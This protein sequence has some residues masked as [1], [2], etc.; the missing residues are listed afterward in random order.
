[1]SPKK[2]TSIFKLAL[3][4]FI[5]DNAI[6]AGAALAYYAIFAI[7]PLILLS[8][9]LSRIFF[10]TNLAKAELSDFLSQFFG[11]AGSK[12]IEIILANETTPKGNITAIVL[13]IIIL[14]FG[15]MG[16][17]Y[18]IRKI[19]DRMWNVKPD[20]HSNKI[21]SFLAKR[22]IALLTVFL[23]GL[24][25]LISLLI[26]SIAHNIIDLTGQIGASAS[27]IEGLNNILTII[28]LTLLFAITTKYLVTEK[29][30]WKKVWLGSIVSSLLFIIGKILFGF[31]L[32][33]IDLGSAYGAAGSLIIFLF[34]LY[35]TANV[36]LFGAEIIK[37]SSKKQPLV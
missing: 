31:Y 32:N 30:P 27:A 17:F 19:L 10:N 29:I 2:T 9:S 11:E 34:W 1:M 16:L 7:A 21:I 20:A 37:V 28:I 22:I 15:S 35:Y 23:A 5:K 13:G 8:I 18:Q 36:F 12:I 26:T 24:L 33:F 6:S 14:L 4:E 25:L 3:V